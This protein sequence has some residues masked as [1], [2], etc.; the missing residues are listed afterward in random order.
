[1]GS[2]KLYA[3]TRNEIFMTGP[4]VQPHPYIICHVS[5]LEASSKGTDVNELE[6]DTSALIIA[7]ENGHEEVWTSKLH[8]LLCCNIPAWA[9]PLS[10]LPLHINFL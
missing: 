1:M 8:H 3:D 6:G 4:P 9:V 5:L 10:G 7:V 2:T